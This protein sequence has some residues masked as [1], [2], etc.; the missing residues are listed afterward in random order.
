MSRRR[1]IHVPGSTYYVYRPVDSG[2]TGFLQP[3]HY[4]LVERLLP[5]ATKHASVR[6]L[7]YCW[8][9]D[10]MHFALQISTKPVGD[11][12]RELTSHFAQLVHRRTG[13][14][15][16]YFRQ[17][18]QPVLIDPDEYLPRLICYLHYLPVSSGLV[19]NPSDYPWSSHR[20]YLGHA[21]TPWLEM[22]PFMQ[23]LGGG[24]K[25]RTAYDRLLAGGTPTDLQKLLTPESASR[26]VILGSAKFIASLLHRPNAPRACRWSLPEVA[27]YVARAHDI[28]VTD[29]RSRSRRHELVV[30]RA[31]I[32][33][34]AIERRVA[35]LNEV[36][37]YLNHSAS[38]L[39]RAITRCQRRHQELF[40]LSAFA[41]L[42]PW[43]PF[44]G[45]RQVR[46]GG[47]DT[48]AFPASGRATTA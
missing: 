9:P 13:E 38:S 37:S 48:R 16:P 35:N 10:A 17:R 41:G 14:R 43:L 44:A 24:E 33:W 31:R 2:S 11:L 15:G 32:S 23:Q 47:L 25:G 34:F 22:K 21:R 27:A 18:Y 30:A 46:T 5:A 36:A 3:P 45:G 28:P 40:V 4:E 12:M 6:L 1:R 26:P 42:T 7:G 20:A 19:R 8:M 29:L 39:T